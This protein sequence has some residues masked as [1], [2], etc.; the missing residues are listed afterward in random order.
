LQPTGEWLNQPGGLAERL[1]RMRK[2]AGLTGDQMAGQFG[3][4][5]TK[6]SKLENGRQMPTEAD[7]RDWARA[8]RQPDA[9]AEMLEQ[10]GEA[11][12][13]HRRYRRQLRRGHAALQ[14]DFDKFVRQANVIRNVEVTVIPGLLQTADYARYRALE[15]VRV[16]GS[17]PGG[18]EDA[19]AARMRRQEVLYDGTREF[20]FIISEAALRFL[21][22][23]AGVML[24]QLDR[25]ASLSGLPNIRIGIIPFGVVLPVAPMLAFMIADDVTCVETHAGDEYRYGDESAEY[26]RIAD[27]LAAEAVTGDEARRL[28]TTAAELLRARASSA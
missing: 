16:H 17:D 4:P 20:E 6:V 15:T 2:A 24:G 8:C 5:R 14:E 13:M 21:L 1:E 11:Q 25:L 12:S 3:W 7:I 10:L 28:M 9:V 23:P 18:A 27:S 26:A 22:C 19:V